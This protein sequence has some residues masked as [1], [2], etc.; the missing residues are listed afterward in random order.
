MASMTS[1]TP[2]TA[3]PPPASS[4]D[5]P[6]PLRAG[7]VLALAF[8]L[9]LAFLVVSISY[10]FAREYGDTA[11]DDV[12]VGGRALRDWGVGVVLVAGLALLVVAL[13]RRSRG[14]RGLT[15]AAVATLVVTL[16][17]VPA[18]A[19]VGVHRKYQAYPAVPD[20]TDGFGGGPAVP[21]VQAAQDAFEEIEH[22]GPFSGGGE[23][24]TNG[25]ASQLMVR[26]DVDV[27]G[28]Y[29]AV[30]PAVGWRLG[31][32]EP[33]LVQATRPGQ[34]FSAARDQDGSWWVRIAPTDG[35]R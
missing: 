11:A 3:S 18:V 25:C 24:G 26:G 10:G 16:V 6:A 14:R 31:R 5:A 23:S 34:R 17:A 9:V 1:T 2:G 7:A 13:G 21:V 27:A 22:P 30:L 35:V 15:V 33:E 20:C 8:T 32:V 29:G 12:V 4:G 28:A 19:V